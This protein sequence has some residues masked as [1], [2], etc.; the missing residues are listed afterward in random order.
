MPNPSSEPVRWLRDHGRYMSPNGAGDEIIAAAVYLRNLG[1][2]HVVLGITTVTILSAA[3]LLRTWAISEWPEYIPQWSGWWFWLSPYIL[4]PAALLGVIAVPF[5]WAYWFI[6]RDKNRQLSDWVAAPT[7][8]LVTITA[9]AVLKQGEPHNLYVLWSLRLLVVIPMFA[10]L[11]WAAAWF[12]A[13]QQ[14]GADVEV[15][16]RSKLSQW[17]A[18]SLVAVAGLVAFAVVD[19]FGLALYD[20]LRSNPLHWSRV[21]GLMGVVAGLITAVSKLAPFLGDKRGERHVSLPKNVIA[22]AGA[23]VVIGWILVSLSA[24][25]YAAAWRGACPDHG[26]PNAM[27]K[28][29]LLWLT[30]GAGV[31][32]LLCGRTIRFVNS[33]SHQAL[34]GNR[35]TRAYL[36]ASNR[37]RFIDSSGRRLSDPIRGDNIGWGEYGPFRSGGPLHIVNVT[38]NETVL[39]ASQVEQRDRKGM[40]VAVGPCGMSGGI[41][42]HALWKQLVDGDATRSN[43]TGRLPGL[44]TDWIKPLPRLGDDRFQLFCGASL[45]PHAVEALS[46]GTW[47]AISGAAFSTGLGARTSLSLSLLLG[48]ANVRLGYW[49]DS[50][51]TPHDRQNARTDPTF[52]NRVGEI[53]NAVLPVQT[54]LF[55]EFTAKFFGPNRTRWYLSDG[56]H[57][58]NTAC[59]ELLASSCAVHRRL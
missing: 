42:S 57:F 37:N 40:L 8:L 1:A 30:I 12:R 53:V 24:L 48:V 44:S 43:W 32:T 20:W 11:A 5:G 22:G 3:M 19:S 23:V 10:L 21:S 55:Q 47:T 7:A 13:T 34:Y 35:L 2:I 33:S 58:E 59:Y 50:H 41:E 17:L 52:R 26:L 39:G 38:L 54:H 46:V 36:G 28:R 31:L 49:W 16:T 15:F 45:A 27:D 6:Q 18:A 51:V 25:T 56:G 29:T 4:L 9:F 14:V